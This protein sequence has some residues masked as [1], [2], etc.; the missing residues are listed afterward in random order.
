M[1]H[2]HWSVEKILSIK[3]GNSPSPIRPQHAAGFFD[4]FH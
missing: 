2:H 1:A 4:I 3:K